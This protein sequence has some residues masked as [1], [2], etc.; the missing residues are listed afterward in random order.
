MKIAICINDLKSREI[1]LAKLL[2]QGYDEKNIKYQILNPKD[3]LTGYDMINLIG[4]K[5][6]E[7]M[8]SGRPYLYF[9]KPYDRKL[10]GWRVA[11]NNHQPTDLMLNMKMRDDRRIKFNWTPPDW[12]NTDGKYILIAGSSLKFHIL[13]NIVDPTAYAENI[14]KELRK[15]GYDEPI[16]YRPKPSWKNAVPIRGAK[17]CRAKTI[18]ESLSLSRVLITYG[19]NSCFEALMNGIPS[20]VLGDGITRDI[21]GNCLESGI[22]YAS[23]SERNQFL[24]NLAYFQY[25][26]KEIAKG[27]L[28]NKIESLL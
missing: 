27:V 8:S 17:F 7:L 4:V 15:Y 25:T 1:E 13:K 10:K 12:D 16:I 21:S 18:Y 14:V 11:I 3:D 6:M 5:S 22:R 28:W 2:A 26:E 19:S 24:N 23:Y 20:I 9:D